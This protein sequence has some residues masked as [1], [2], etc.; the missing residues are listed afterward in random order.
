MAATNWWFSK[1]NGTR[2]R[3]IKDNNLGGYYEDIITGKNFSVALHNGPGFGS[4][5]LPLRA[6]QRAHTGR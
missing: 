1:K 4:P 6:A 5:A 2:P 3:S